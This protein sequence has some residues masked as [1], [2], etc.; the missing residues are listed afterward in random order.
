MTYKTNVDELNERL[1]LPQAFLSRNDI[2]LLLSCNPTGT[3]LR[4]LIQSPGFPAPLTI[5][6]KLQRWKAKE[7]LAYIENKRFG[8][9]A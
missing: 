9:C 4:K 3:G 7:V 1:K 5:G 6:S 8:I 2:A